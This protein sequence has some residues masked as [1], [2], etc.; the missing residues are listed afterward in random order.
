MIFDFMVKKFAGDRGE[1]LAGSLMLPAI[2]GREF[3][4]PSVSAISIALDSSS[5]DPPCVF[6]QRRQDG[7]S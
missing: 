2:K 4:I 6:H 5:S 7:T 1:L 3:K